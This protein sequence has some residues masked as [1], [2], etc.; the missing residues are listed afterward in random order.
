MEKMHSCANTLNVFEALSQGVSRALICI[1]LTIGSAAVL[2]GEMSVGELVGFYSLC[3]FLTVP[4]GTL[5]NAGE[6]IARTTV[7]G[8]RIFEILDLPDESSQNRGLPP[9]EVSKEIQFHS[10]EFRFPG[11]E[12]L[13]N[14]LS[15]SIPAGKITLLR[16]ESGCG[17]STLAK[18]VLRDYA[19]GQ[20]MICCGG[21]NIAQF[22]LQQW[23]DSIGY[24]PQRIHLF[25]ASIL[26]NITLGADNPDMERVLGI[27]LSLGMEGMIRKFPQGLLTLTGEKGTGLSGGEC[28]KIAIARALYKNPQIYILD[29]ATSSLDPLGEQCVLKTLQELRDAGKTILFI[30][31]KETGI[32]MAD[33]VIT[34]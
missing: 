11:R 7:S 1:I 20:G 32:S 23:R 2:K 34:I 33:N 15:L 17:K 25:N 8:G 24:V 30:S 6:K 27:C 16:G 29:E 18:L 31:H 9:Q 26:E 19:P 5:I 4:L 28:Q 12:T 13:L 21:V 10:V 3:T 22:H 14:G